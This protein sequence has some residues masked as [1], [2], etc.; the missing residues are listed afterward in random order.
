M[1]S[2]LILTEGDCPGEAHSTWITIVRDCCCSGVCLWSGCGICATRPCCFDIDTTT[3]NTIISTSSTSIRGVTLTCGLD[4]PPP[5]I[6]KAIDLLLS[7][8][9]SGKIGHPHRQAGSRERKLHS[10]RRFDRTG[11]I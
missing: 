10:L 8:R 4:G 9:V 6:E 2:W 7:A 11:I 3:M 1:S 5:A